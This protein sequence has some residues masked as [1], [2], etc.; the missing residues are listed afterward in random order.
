MKPLALRASLCLSVLFVISGCSR[1]VARELERSYQP[2][3]PKLMPEKQGIEFPS[4][5]PTAVVEIHG[6]VPG[7]DYS[8]WQSTGVCLQAGDVLYIR[9]SGQINYVNDLTVGPDGR[10]NTFYPSLLPM[11]SF[12]ALIGRTHFGLLND[13]I[14]SSGVG[15]YG[16]GFV[17]SEFKTIYGGRSDYG[18][19][20]D[21]ALYLAVNDSMD[22]DNG[23]SLTAEIWVVRDGK[24]LD[25]QSCR[26][27]APAGKS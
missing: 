14:D 15:L 8:T 19:T 3:T 16:P 12:M 1:P 10:G 17:G 26:P 5:S 11:V 2:I 18:L 21:N 22:N 25:G 4:T 9:A 27:P 7:V 13:G 24:A 6:D 20:G 23:L